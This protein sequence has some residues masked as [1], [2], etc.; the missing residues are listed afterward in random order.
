MGLFKDGVDLIFGSGGEGG[1]FRGI[2]G[3]KESRTAKREARKLKR[4][5]K[6]AGLPQ[7]SETGAG[8]LLGSVGSWIQ[9][10]WT[11]V[12]LSVGAFFLLTQLSKKKK[13][14]RRRRKSSVSS[15]RRRT[16]PTKRKRTRTKRKPTA[17][18]RKSVRKSTGSSIP[19]KGATQARKAD[20]TVIRGKANVEAYRKRLL[21]LR[22]ARKAR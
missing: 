9:Q 15:K 1:L 13:V 3:T 12:A 2:F 16:T 5:V 22:K 6:Q 18:R 17:T 11:L 10:N 20:G 7:P 19:K 8:Q 14:V 4:A 21:N